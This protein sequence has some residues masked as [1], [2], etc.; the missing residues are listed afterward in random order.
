MNRTRCRNGKR[1]STFVRR[2]ITNARTSTNRRVAKTPVGLC[3][4]NAS[5]VGGPTISTRGILRLLPDPNTGITSVMDKLIAGRFVEQAQTDEASAKL[6][7][8]GFAPARVAVFF[9]N[10]PGQHDRYPI[11]GDR[12]ES[13][14]TRSAAAGAAAGAAGGVALG[15]A[16]GALLGPAGAL[17]GAAV[18][19]YVG[20]LPGALDDMQ[21]QRTGGRGLHA[22]DVPRIRE[23]GMLVA[24]VTPDDASES[25]AIEVLRSA[26]A[27][28]IERNT[29]EI[30][31]GDWVDFDPL[32]K[33][34]TLIQEP[35]VRG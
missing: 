7:Q 32:A 34:G 1:K 18:G 10:S 5:R 24:V 14:G 35:G 19:A 26:G 9:V 11:G 16:A 3:R 21:A 25:R 23:A 6:A 30:R 13:P 28:D 31:D 8:A 27:T 2:M 12:D 4:H 17:A 20:S 33:P 15:A 22:D 29:G